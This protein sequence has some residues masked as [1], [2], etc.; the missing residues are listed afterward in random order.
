MEEPKILTSLADGSVK[1]E[2]RLL[3]RTISITEEQAKELMLALSVMFDDYYKQEP[4]Y[5]MEGKNVR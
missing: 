2:D 5:P 4:Q 1:I 3:G